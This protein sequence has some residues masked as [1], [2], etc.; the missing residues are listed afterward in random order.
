MYLGRYIFDTLTLSNDE[1]KVPIDSFYKVTQYT[2][3][4]CGSCILHDERNNHDI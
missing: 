1:A 2:S 4:I 3:K